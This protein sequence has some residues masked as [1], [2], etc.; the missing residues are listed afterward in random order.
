ML[1]RSK[2][3]NCRHCGLK[4]GHRPGVLCVDC[5]AAPEIKSQYTRRKYQRH[6][7]EP[8]PTMEELEV[9][10]A[11]QLPTMPGRDEDDE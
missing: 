9:M 1:T 2:R 11:E 6:D 10:I 8:E 4:T 7:N 5:Y 3:P